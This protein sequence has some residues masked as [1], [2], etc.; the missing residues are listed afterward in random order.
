MKLG[1]QEFFYIQS[2]NFTTDGFVKATATNYADRKL[3]TYAVFDNLT[4]S[5]FTMEI[6][7]QG[8]NRAAIAGLQVVQ[9]PEPSSFVLTAI[10]GLSALG[11]WCGR[12]I[13]H[14]TV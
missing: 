8:G 6:I 11:L 13:R 12:R 10:G 9:L 4:D 2:S 3:A 1:S 14:R 7:K 5:A